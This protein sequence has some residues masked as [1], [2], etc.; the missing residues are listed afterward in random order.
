MP[1]VL[2]EYR[3]LLLNY[4]L[5]KP[6]STSGSTSADADV[7]VDAGEDDAWRHRLKQQSESMSAAVERARKRRE[8]EERRLREEQMAAA[9][10]K[11][12]LLDEKFGKKQS[13]V[14]FN[15]AS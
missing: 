12:R 10:E 11:L 14:S 15:F 13:K 3:C 4:L 7:G 5:Q 2:L 1:N 9:R 6:V 8:E